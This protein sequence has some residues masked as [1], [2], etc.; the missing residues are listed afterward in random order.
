MLHPNSRAVV[1][2]LLPGASLGG[3]EQWGGLSSRPLRLDR[4]A[5]AREG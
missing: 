5:C 1:L 4:T 2:V 3:G